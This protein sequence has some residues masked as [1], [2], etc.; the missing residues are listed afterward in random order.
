MDELLFFSFFSDFTGHTLSGTDDSVV[1][2][3]PRHWNSIAILIRANGSLAQVGR[4]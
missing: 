3:D 2:Q 1:F 4:E